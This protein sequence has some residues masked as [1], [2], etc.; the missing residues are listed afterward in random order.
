MPRYI[1]L[2]NL[3]NEGDSRTV[4]SQVVRLEK[5]LQSP[6]IN[7]SVVDVYATLG[8]FDIVV[9][10]EIADADRAGAFA[11][12]V[13]DVLNGST[14]TL[15]ALDVAQVDRALAVVREEIPRPAIGR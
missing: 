2:A 3:G 8:V 12:G 7:G 6:S 4:A 1:T 9:V 13:R 5:L 14:V 15:T 11:A 10:S